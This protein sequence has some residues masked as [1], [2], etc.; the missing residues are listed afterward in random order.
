MS[1]P[2]TWNQQTK[3]VVVN[4]IIMWYMCTKDFSD[5]NLNEASVD[6]IPHFC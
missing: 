3:C 4:H 5:S 2:F 1:M 6:K